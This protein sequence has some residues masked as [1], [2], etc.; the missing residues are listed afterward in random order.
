MHISVLTIAIHTVHLEGILASLIL[1]IAV[2]LAQFLLLVQQELLRTVIVHTVACL[3]V[4]GRHHAVLVVLVVK[5][6]TAAGQVLRLA[7]LDC[8]I[9]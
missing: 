5:P 9:A 3:V 1:C 6:A 2:L 8:L 4:S 7:M